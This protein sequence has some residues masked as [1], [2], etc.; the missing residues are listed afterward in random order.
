LAA[1]SANEFKL[2][3]GLIIVLMELRTSN[4]SMCVYTVL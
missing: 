3:S 2:S 1:R 4:G